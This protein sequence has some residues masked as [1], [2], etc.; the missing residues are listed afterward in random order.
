MINRIKKFFRD[1]LKDAEAKKIIELQQ[2]IDS[3][4][5]AVTA[6]CESKYNR[7]IRGC[8][9]YIGRG[10]RCPDCP[11]DYLITDNQGD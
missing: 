5:E 3:H 7:T 2:R 10:K 4:N 11:M 9:S 6:D 8:E 1:A